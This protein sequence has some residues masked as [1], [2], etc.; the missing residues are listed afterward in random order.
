MTRLLLPAALAALALSSAAVAGEGFPTL[1]P[2]R[3]AIIAG[4]HISC[5]TTEA[6]VTCRKPGGLTAT[7]LLTGQVHVTRG[8]RT[9]FA[10][11]RPMMLHNN[12]GFTSVWRDGEAVYCHVYLAAALTVS[13]SLADPGLVKRSHGF[14]MSDGSVVV[15]RYQTLGIQNDIRHDLKTIPQP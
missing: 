9:L 11:T 3:S 13:C 6:S 1:Q 2:G 10:A 4:T 8:S 12:N 14:D 15:F 5:Q 7:I